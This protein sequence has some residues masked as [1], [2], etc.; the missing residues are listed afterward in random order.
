MKKISLILFLFNLIFVCL[1]STNDAQQPSKVQ[2]EAGEFIGRG[3]I[4]GAIAA[5]DKAIEQRKDL[6]DA[7]KLRS[8][9]RSMTGDFAGALADLSAAIDLKSDGSLYQH[10]AMMRMNLRQDSSL[11]LKDLDAAIAA[12]KNI[13][14]V[15][16]LR[17]M[18]KR[19]AGDEAGAIADYQTAIGLR[20]DFAQAH[21]GL[22]SIY[23]LRR[24][25]E[26]AAAVLENFVGIY[27][28]AS[29]ETKTID[30]DVISSAETKTINGKILASGSTM[31]PPIVAEKG[32]AKTTVRTMQGVVIIDSGQTRRDA[33]MSQE[34]L[35]K[36]SDDFGQTKNVALAY[37]NLASIYRERKDYDRAFAAVEKALKIDRTDFGAYETRGKINADKGDFQQAIADFDRTLKMMPGNF[38][39]YLE[40]GAAFLMLGRDAE[41]QRDF[42]SFL[43]ASPFP[44]EKE[45]VDKRVEAT[46]KRR[47]EI[48]SQPK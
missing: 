40:R 16:T 34:G 48:E 32:D 30:G 12:G 45:I 14:S 10:R 15:Y 31:L 41:A 25:D 26:K 24:D 23:L 4:K 36:M 20:P 43:T 44:N 11:I 9:L 37:S 38:F 5:L 17:A 39:T 13:E 29:A 27:E 28:N 1:V 21:V 42:D 46:L 33:P 18:I 35:D 3:D 7:Y 2:H 6:F 47:A 8:D 19:Q 22:A